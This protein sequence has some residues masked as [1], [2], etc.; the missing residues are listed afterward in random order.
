MNETNKVALDKLQAQLER[1]LDITE[2]KD[3]LV[4]ADD[5]A[6]CLAIVLDYCNRDTL[7]GNMDKAVKDLFIIRYNRE[8]N[9][10]EESRT[11]GGVSIT[12]ET[13]V[14]KQLRTTLN[15]YRVGSVSSL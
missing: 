15:N 1:K 8:G 3:K 9:E 5:L 14:P 11:E 12:F 10:G 13:G 6:D 4:L 7:V 2:E